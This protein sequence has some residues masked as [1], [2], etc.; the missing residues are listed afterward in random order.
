VSRRTG[1]RGVLD[2]P[3]TRRA[4]GRYAAF[5][6]GAAAMGG[7]RLPTALAAPTLSGGEI[8]ILFQSNWQGSSWNTT[9]QK[10]C[11]AFVDST[12]NSM[13]QYRGIRAVVVPNGQGAAG[14]I[15]GSALAAAPGIPDVVE[16][17]CSDFPTYVS[18]GFLAPL[19][20]QLKVD[21]INVYN[22]FIRGHLEALSEDGIIYALPS[23]DAPPTMYYRQDILDELGLG[24]PDP[25]WTYQDAEKIW[26]ACTSVKAGSVR[27]G[28]T[29]YTGVEMEYL[30]RGWGTSEM[31]PDRT[32]CLLD[33]PKAIA[34]GEWLYDLILSGVA[35]Y[36]TDSGGLFG[37][38]PQAVFAMSG[39]WSLLP[40]AVNLRGVKWN[41]LPMP[42]WP[43]G[44]STTFDNIDFYGMY[45]GTKHPQAAWEFMRWITTQPDYTRFLMRVNLIGPALVSLWDEYEAIVKAAAPPLR[46]KDLFYIKEAALSGRAYPH[47]FFRYGFSQADNILNEWFG[48]IGA[49]QVSVA[50][51]FTQAARQVNAWEQQALK[52]EQEQKALVRAIESTPV[53]PNSNYPAPS[54][55]GIGVPP[56]PT[57][58]IVERDGTFVLLGD[59]WDCWEASDNTTLACIPVTET[60]GEWSCRVVLISN[61]TC[62]HLSQWAKVGLMARADL[63]DDAPAAYVHVTGAHQIEWQARLQAGM[64]PSSQSGL[65]PN[66]GN[67]G[68]LTL[69]N[70]KPAANYLIKPVWL[71]LS[72]KGV[73][74]TAWGSFDGVHWQQLG[75]P[76]IAQMGGCWVGIQACAHNGSFNNQGYIRAVIDHVSFQPT[77]FVQVGQTGVPPAA[78]KVPADWAKL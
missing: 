30:L 73:T 69:P 71:K 50:E 4:L 7:L 18:A 56:T 19:N 39:G 16:D 45:A 66:P 61:L 37:A 41:I 75:T 64:T 76:Q 59:G 47:L 46:D 38:K 48:K 62:P 1:G 33:D 43:S 77:H 8:Q 72:R 6:A 54:V 53:R 63:S 23:Y 22:L 24:Y 58:Y 29:L 44:Y 21:N 52:Y 5:A 11:Q 13:P 42:R 36:R 57:P 14:T 25:N 12:F 2:G 49:K 60:E 35:G 51:G 31:T 55:T 28:V 17:C 9:A 3:V 27:N 26:R 67:A 65:T 20:D 78:G 70:T 74:W 10:L 15:I 68:T 40:A 32:V 34:A